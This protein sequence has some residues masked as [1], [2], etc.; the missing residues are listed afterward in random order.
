VAL[1]KTNPRPADLQHDS[2]SAGVQHACVVGGGLA[3]LARSIAVASRGVR[4]DLFDRSHTLPTASAFVEVVPNMLRDLVPLGVADDC[5][6][7]GFA[8]QG[9]DV[10]DRQGRLV[11]EIQTPRLAGMR[12]P[13]ALGI[14]HDELLRIL[15]RR[16]RA[17]GVQMHRGADVAAIEQRGGRA[18]L[19][20]VSGAELLTDLV[21]VAA[22]A[23]SSVGTPHFPHAGNPPDPSDVAQVWWY[24]L[25]HRPRALQRPKVFVGSAGRKVMVV[26]IRGDLAG[27]ALIEPAR[28]GNG[29]SLG[30]PAAHVRTA[31]LRFPDMV[32]ELARQLDD[33]TPVARRPVF[34]ALLPEPWHQEQIIAVGNAAHSMPP[35]F[36]QA[37]AQALEDACVLSDLLVYARGAC[38]VARAF[39]ARRFGRASQVHDI[40][41]TAARWDL[42]PESATDLQELSR[43]LFRL[44]VEPA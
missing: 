29:V 6:K 9:L 13:A 41:V 28:P 36:G 42:A 43:R 17:C 21:I 11:L 5:V 39:T 32:Q 37:G 8:Y 35:H 34:S 31:L 33:D 12:Y 38:E 15:D 10:I 22:G 2:G 16:A 4:V 26:P 30:L 20:L 27:V 7:A 23:G 18:A 24:A 40:A 25:V 1:C 19:Q 14:E 3:G 44:V